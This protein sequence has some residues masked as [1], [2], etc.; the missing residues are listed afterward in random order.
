MLTCPSS[1]FAS[2]ATNW[3]SRPATSLPCR[4]ACA[5]GCTG[6]ATAW[7]PRSTVRWTKT[8]ALWISVAVRS[9]LRTIVGRVG[10]SDAPAHRTSRHPGSLPGG[11]G[12]SAICR[13]PLG[14]SRRT[15][16][17]CC[18]SP[19]RRRN[20][21]PNTSAGGCSTRSKGNAAFA[22][23]VRIEIGEGTGCSAVCELQHRPARTSSL[24]EIASQ[25]SSPD[26]DKGAR[27]FPRRKYAPWRP[28]ISAKPP[29]C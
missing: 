3:F 5:S 23:R 1:T 20:C 17:C 14:L 9:A 29:Y 2:P 7:R 22:Q 6:T 4:V 13:S 24:A 21:W 8:S 10:P 26:A 19:T 28:P 15:I 11:G 27:L 16:V 25:V 18:R 12:R